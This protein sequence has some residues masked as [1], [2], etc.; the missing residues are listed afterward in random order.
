MTQQQTSTALADAYQR[1]QQ[2]EQAE[3][4][5]QQAQRTP[6]QK[7]IEAQQEITR[8]E[9]QQRGERFAAAVE[10][11]DRLLSDHAPLIA[12]LRAALDAWDVKAG[13]EAYRAVKASYQRQQEHKQQALAIIDAE[14]QQTWQRERERLL[15]I[16]HTANRADT[17]AGRTARVAQ[18]GYAAKLT[19]AVHPRPVLDQF[20]GPQPRPADPADFE[21]E[22]RRGVMIAVF[23]GGEI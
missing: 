17:D 20:V 15:S 18:G 14:L 6:Q 11:N 10:Y 3:N 8:L 12:T 13:I 19:D 7:I 23:G 9:A 4:E 5:R 2:A 22:I 21:R 1:L 16:G